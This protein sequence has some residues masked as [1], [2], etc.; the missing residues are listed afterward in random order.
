MCGQCTQPQNRWH[1]TVSSPFHYNHARYGIVVPRQPQDTRSPALWTR[2]AFKCRKEKNIHWCHDTCQHVHELLIPAAVRCKGWV[3]GRPLAG[4][5]G[6]N[7]AW[8]WMSVCCQ[9][10]VSG[11][12][13]S[14]VHRSPAEYGVCLSMISKPQQHA[15][16]NPLGTV[17]LRETKSV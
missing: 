7:P 1:R 4:T 15:G 2:T 6:S 8:A 9:L 17:E 14:L 13:L 5:A 16:P 3:C 12:G 10:E 11:T